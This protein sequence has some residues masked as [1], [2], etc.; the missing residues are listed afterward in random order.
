MTCSSSLGIKVDEEAKNVGVKVYS[1]H[2]DS[3]ISRNLTPY[4]Q[5]ETTIFITKTTQSSAFINP[6]TKDL[7][8]H[9]STISKIPEQF[10]DRK[11][12]RFEGKSHEKGMY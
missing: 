6:E 9:P 2:H 10:N 3:D 7:L 4:H 11:P 1:L 5:K 12:Q 8:N